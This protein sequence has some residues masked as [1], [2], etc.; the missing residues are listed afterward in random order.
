[1]QGQGMRFERELR[2]RG[3]DSVL[4]CWYALAAKDV[5]EPRRSLGTLQPDRIGR[6]P[7]YSPR[8]GTVAGSRY[9]FVP[10][11]GSVDPE[12]AHPARGAACRDWPSVVMRTNAGKWRR[13]CQPYPKR[14][15]YR[16]LEWAGHWR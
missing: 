7:I 9:R 4:L 3:Y 11:I 14:H 15:P 10:V 6:R 16:Q 12:V 5:T 8:D 2:R 1:M 13:N